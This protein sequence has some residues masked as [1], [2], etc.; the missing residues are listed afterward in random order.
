VR[1]SLDRKNLLP[2][3]AMLSLAGGNPDGD[4]SLRI[5][6]TKSKPSDVTFLEPTFDL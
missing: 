2:L 4:S 1:L 6:L 5:A 3:L